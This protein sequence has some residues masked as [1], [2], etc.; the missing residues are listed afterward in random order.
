M[1]VNKMKKLN[2]LLLLGVA[3]TSAM[4]LSSCGSDLTEIGILQF[5][6]FDALENCKDGFIS[7]LEDAGFVDGENVKFTIQNPEGDSSTQDSMAINLATN[8]DMVFGISTG[9][10]QALKNAVEDQGKDTPV[11]F[12]AVTDPVAAG[13]VT[14]FTE[15]GNVVGTSDAGPTDK[16]IELFTEF[17]GIDKIGI[18]YNSAES[19]SII[20]KNEAVEACEELGLTL[21]DGGIS[22]Q[23]EIDSTIQNF[24]AQGVQ[25]LFIPTDNT[26]ALAIEGM[27][28]TLEEN[29]I[30]TVCADA[31]VT[32]EGGSLGYSVDYENLGETTGKMAAKILNGVDISTIPCSK[33]ESFPLS[34]REDF[35]TNTG[36]AIPESIQAILESQEA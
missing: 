33:S 17:E 23:T 8:S 6:T 19:N 14:S 29:K 27:K 36:I 32:A 2:L 22:S 1:E 25:G 11:L 12:S 4:G 3:T 35:F 24:V 34:L 21:V 15:H 31:L 26:I 7:A 30:L 20:Q 13:L 16:N 18:I 5:G 9:S 10:S 28:D